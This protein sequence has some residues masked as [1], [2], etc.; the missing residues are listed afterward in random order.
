MG[1]CKALDNATRPE[2][3][4][5]EA[6]AA[7][8]KPTGRIAQAM[9]RVAERLPNVETS[10]DLLKPGVLSLELQDDDYRGSFD[11]DTRSRELAKRIAADGPTVVG[12]QLADEYLRL[13]T[14]NVAFRA[15]EQAAAA[16]TWRKDESIAFLGNDYVVHFGATRREISFEPDKLRAL[17]SRTTPEA[18]LRKTFAADPQFAADAIA[19]LKNP[20]PGIK[21]PTGHLKPRDLPPAPPLRALDETIV[22]ELDAW[23]RKTL[24][25][26]MLQ[27]RTIS[28][29]RNRDLFDPA[30]DT[31]ATP[32]KWVRVAE[33]HIGE[34]WLHPT[35]VLILLDA[36]DPRGDEA[37]RR[38]LPH[39]QP[40]HEASN[41]DVEVVWRYRHSH[42]DAAQSLVHG[43]RER[44]R[45]LPRPSRQARRPG[46][47][48]HRA[49]PRRRQHAGRPRRQR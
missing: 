2:H 19:A 38:Y 4:T 35:A 37:A 46:R 6:L 24:A 21:L 16:R 10:N 7:A 33:R 11:I 48:A 22:A 30:Q 40:H 27:E 26:F 39:A 28:E 8:A 5:P 43:D 17:L 41:A 47:T 1:L 44:R 36:G 34:H 12:D 14:A 31:W 15:I 29:Y 45:P 18:A 49:T 23:A 42:P 13:S 20:Q 3:A 9:L 32:A 25:K